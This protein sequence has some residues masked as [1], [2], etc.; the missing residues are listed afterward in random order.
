ME[1]DREA[2]KDGLK[3][4]DFPINVIVETS[5]FCNLKCSICPN[6]FMKRE[7]GN[8]SFDVF[9]KVADELPPETTLWL[10]LLG[11]PL[12]NPNQL[13]DMVYYA[14]RIGLKDV[15]LNTNGL[16]LTERIS[17]EL[18]DA[19]LDYVLISV[20]AFEPST[21]KKIR[22]GG[23]LRKLVENV[24]NLISIR[25]KS[26]LKVVVQFIVMEENEEEVEFF[27]DFWL[28]A[29]AIV[30]IRPKL[31]WG[32]TIEAKNLNLEQKDRTYPC[33]WLA[34]TVSI[35]W[36]GR[37]AQCDFDYEGEYSPGDIRTQSIKEIWDGEILK[38]R[39]KHVA[40]DFTHP[41]CSTCKDWQVGLAQYFGG[42]K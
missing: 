20:D 30:K 36:T 41:L 26:Q 6:P 9:K 2:I 13:I 4:Y 21:Y 18:V 10:A 42:K 8:M 24:D 15:R 34:R 12:M 37:L 25:N 7:K 1:F 14:K 40:G 3:L 35:Q 23:N 39:Q 5:S 27:K 32:N 11:E 16:L 22:I 17:A 28:E 31:S 29:G 33:P 19:G 38:R